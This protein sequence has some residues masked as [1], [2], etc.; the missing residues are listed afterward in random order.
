MKKTG[1]RQ[2]LQTAKISTKE[3]KNILDIRTNP[4]TYWV[5]YRSKTP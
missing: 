4:K 5:A 1:Y 3:E 2:Q